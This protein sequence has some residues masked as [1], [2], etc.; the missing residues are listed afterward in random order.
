MDSI[1]DFAM[2]AFGIMLLVA[3][4]AVDIGLLL[5]IAVAYV[6]NLI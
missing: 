4:F 2:V 3:W 5:W 6:L 1:K